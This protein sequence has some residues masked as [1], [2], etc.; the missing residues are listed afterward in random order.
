MQLALNEGANLPA[1]HRVGGVDLNAFA[2]EVMTAMLSP[3]LR[4]MGD[5]VRCAMVCSAERS[6]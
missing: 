3:V 2:A 6:R 1:A 5:G 4:T